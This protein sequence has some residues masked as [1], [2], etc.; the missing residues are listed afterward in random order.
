MNGAP[1]DLLALSVQGARWQ[2]I[3][4]ILLITV[5]LATRLPAYIGDVYGEQDEARLVVDALAWAQAG[6]R[7]EALS[8]YRYYTSPGYIGLIVVVAKLARIADISLA[9]LLGAF[10]FLLS[11]VIVVPAYRLAIRLTDP[12]TALLAGLA[13]LFMP[14][15]WHASTYGFPHLPALFCLICAYLLYDRRIAGEPLIGARGDLAVVILLLVACALFKADVYLG[16]AGLPALLLLR[17]KVTL[18]RVVE[19]ALILVIPVLAVV[20]T[21]QM[22]LQ[23]SPTTGE[24]MQGYERQY[25]LALWH[26]KSWWLVEGW[27]MAFGFYAVPVFALGL[28]VALVRGRWALVALLVLWIAAPFAFWFFRP[29]DSARHHLPEAFPVALGVGIAIA[30]LSGRRWLRYGVLALLVGAGYL[31]YPPTDD[32]FR[33][34]GRVPESAQM[35]RARMLHYHHLAREYQAMPA[36]RK[37][38]LGTITNP[39]VDAEVLWAAER[40]VRIERRPL[41]G[42]DAIQIASIGGGRELFSASVRLNAEEAPAAARRFSDQ[43][44]TVYS[45]EYDLVLGKRI[46]PRRLDTLERK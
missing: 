30:A 4:L 12:E 17:N 36:P 2:G 21:A 19:L 13:M 28:G 1:M 11:I 8:E 33:T 25:P 43:G 37:V 31:R 22:L 24:Y 5:A 10:N 16:A 44:Y 26:L 39:Y 32:N 40:V 3:I 6:V 38:L 45:I 35:V 15:L 20:G 9:S 46:A 34:G 23:A 14:M 29:G 27:M 7:N 18:R 42:Y 41:L